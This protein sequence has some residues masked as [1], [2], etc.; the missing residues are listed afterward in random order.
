VQARGAYSLLIIEIASLLS[1]N[2]PRAN[3]PI[4]PLLNT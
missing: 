2:H 4:F 1:E 3:A